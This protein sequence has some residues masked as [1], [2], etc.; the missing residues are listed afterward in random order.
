MTSRWIIEIAITRIWKKIH[1]VMSL[2][3]MKKLED[4]RNTFFPIL[5]LASWTTKNAGLGSVLLLLKNIDRENDK[6]PKQ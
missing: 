5:E 1:V 4:F 6:G 3:L 2:E